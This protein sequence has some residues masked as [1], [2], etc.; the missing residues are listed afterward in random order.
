MSLIQVYHDGLETIAMI[1]ERALSIYEERGWV[2]VEE[3]EAP[4]PDSGNPRD[5]GNDSELDNDDLESDE[6]TSD[7]Y[8]ED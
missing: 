1:P 4:F 3:V 5:R 7:N 6:D 8:Q 2:A